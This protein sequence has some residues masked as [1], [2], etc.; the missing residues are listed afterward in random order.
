MFRQ[1][2][3]RPQ[4]LHAEHETL[5]AGVIHR[6]RQQSPVGAW[7]DHADFAEAVARGQ[8]IDIEQHFLGRV[9]RPVPAA[10]HGV[11]PAGLGARVVEILAALLGHGAVLFLY[12]RLHLAEEHSLQF[13]RLRHHRLGV[14]V[15][16]FEIIEH[17][18]IAP[19]AE[20]VVV[21]HAC[22]AVLGEGKRAFLRAGWEA[23]IRH[24]GHFIPTQ[25][26]DAV[27]GK[28]SLLTTAPVYG[29]GCRRGLT[30]AVSPS[31]ASRPSARA[32]ASIPAQRAGPARGAG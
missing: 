21:V 29:F 31:S 2:P 15:L 25:K 13:A 11:L 22:V 12:P 26:T 18:C 17:K 1:Q 6:V 32:P 19:V 30:G 5:I 8:G 3:A 14:G 20:P 4:I 10:V 16:G 28:A 9:G 24:A 7:L 23:M 27:S